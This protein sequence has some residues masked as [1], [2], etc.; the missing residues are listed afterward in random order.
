[1]GRKSKRRT[2]KGGMLE[3]LMGSKPVVASVSTNTKTPVVASEGAN[4]QKNE[5][6]QK[7][8]SPQMNEKKNATLAGGSRRRKSRKSRKSVRR[9]KR[10]V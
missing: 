9:K 10:F 6:P 2:R 4:P 8:E 5:S 3:W 7:I 1:M